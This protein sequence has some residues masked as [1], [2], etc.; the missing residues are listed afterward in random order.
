[1]GEPEGTPSTR[2]GAGSGLHGS[3]GGTTE[4]RKAAGLSGAGHAGAAGTGRDRRKKDGKQ[5]PDYLVEDEETWVQ[6]RD[7]T[8]RVIE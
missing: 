7:N 2:T 5:V 8:P 3:R 1:M 6:K 4:G